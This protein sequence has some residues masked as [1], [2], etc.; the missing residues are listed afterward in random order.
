M[1][2]IGQKRAEGNE[3]TAPIF[4]LYYTDVISSLNGEIDD[5]SL[6]QA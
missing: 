6:F 5:V 3:S 1:A 4:G 2:A